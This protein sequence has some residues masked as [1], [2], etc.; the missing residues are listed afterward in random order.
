MNGDCRLIRMDT[1]GNQR[2]TLAEFP[3]GDFTPGSRYLYY[4]Y[5]AYYCGNYAWAELYYG[6]MEE[7]GKETQQIQC[8]A[9]DLESGEVRNLHA[10]GHR[11]PI[12][13]CGYH[14]GLCYDL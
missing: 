12:S 14:G 11:S 4:V 10:G 13:V 8:V 5:N 3:Q 1:S 6:Y 2:K 7:D 9:V